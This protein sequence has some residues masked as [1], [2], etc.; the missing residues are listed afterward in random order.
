[1][2]SNFQQDDEAASER[3][4]TLTGRVVPL[5]R[6]QY[7]FD[8]KHFAR[9]ASTCSA[10]TLSANKLYHVERRNYKP[11]NVF[12]RELAERVSLRSRGD[13]HGGHE[14]GHQHSHSHSHTHGHNDEHEHE[15]KQEHSHHGH[16]THHAA[17]H[18]EV[19]TPPPSV[20]C[21]P[22]QFSARN[23]QRPNRRLELRKR[24]ARANSL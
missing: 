22:V 23:V 18:T 12:Q 15:H 13:E 8:S 6:M 16:A 5:S 21:S 3:G 17:A 10:S 19:S 1:M 14:H 4:S 2:T 11:P 20:G 7:H 9:A 24:A